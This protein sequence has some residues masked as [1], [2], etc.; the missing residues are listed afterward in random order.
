M[1]INTEQNGILFHHLTH[2]TSTEID[3][4]KVKFKKLA[5]YCYKDNI[6]RRKTEIFVRSLNDL[7]SLCRYWSHSGYT[8]KPIIQ[9]KA[10]SSKDVILD[11]I[12]ELDCK[13][14]CQ[15]KFS[16]AQHTTAGDFRSEG[17]FSPKLTIDEFNQIRCSS[18]H[19]ESNESKYD[20][21]PINHDGRCGMLNL[22]N[23]EFV[24]YFDSFLE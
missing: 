4:I 22:V 3:E 19:E 23:G 14:N 12:I 10:K 20:L 5:Y 21:C 1:I 13:Q 8:Y 11:P 18:C 17:G 7:F 6:R 16:C 15:Y 9:I 2:L 24:S